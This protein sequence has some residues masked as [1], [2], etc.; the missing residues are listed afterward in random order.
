MITSFAEL[1]SVQLETSFKNQYIKVYK[2]YVNIYGDN[3][4]DFVFIGV[5]TWGQLFKIN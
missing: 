4:G 2:L 5:V 3:F 1:I